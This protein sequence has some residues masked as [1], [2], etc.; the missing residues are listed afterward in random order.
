MKRKETR[1]IIQISAIEVSNEHFSFGTER[2]AGEGEGVV[3]GKVMCVKP[4]VRQSQTISSLQARKLT[5]SRKMDAVFVPLLA[6]G[7]QVFYTFCGRVRITVLCCLNCTLS[8][9]ALTFDLLLGSWHFRR[10]V[11]SRKHNIHNAQ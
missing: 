6:V 2:G 1:C 4:A 5:S 8:S 10:Q 11:A 9:T 7:C 3:S